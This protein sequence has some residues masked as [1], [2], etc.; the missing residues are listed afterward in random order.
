MGALRRLSSSGY[1]QLRQ[2]RHLAIIAVR[3]F[4]EQTQQRSKIRQPG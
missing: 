1:R 2:L 4:T 3:L